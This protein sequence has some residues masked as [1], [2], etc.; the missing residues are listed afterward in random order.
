MTFEVTLERPSIRLEDLA[1]RGVLKRNPSVIILNEYSEDEI[2]LTP[3][4]AKDL[5]WKLLKYAKEGHRLD[6]ALDFTEKDVTLEEASTALMLE[7]DRERKVRGRDDDWE[8]SI[9][10]CFQNKY[11]WLQKRAGKWSTLE[12]K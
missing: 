7:V 6:Q 10:F 12:W 5:A 1:Y 8:G 4:E 2:K 11:Y 3:Q 9:R